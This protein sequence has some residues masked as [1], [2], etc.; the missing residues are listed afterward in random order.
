MWIAEIYTKTLK[1]SW[2]ENISALVRIEGWVEFWEEQKIMV[3]V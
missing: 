1:Q 2:P 3:D